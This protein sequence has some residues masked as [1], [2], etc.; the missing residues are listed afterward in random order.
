MG[1]HITIFLDINC[2]QYQNIIKTMQ[3]NIMD[4]EHPTQQPP[5]M[6]KPPFPLHT[7][8]NIYYKITMN[9]IIVIFH[10]KN[11][12]FIAKNTPKSFRY[13]TDTIPKEAHTQNDCQKSHY[14]TPFLYTKSQVF[15]KIEILIL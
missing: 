5:N 10:T 14:P 1:S 15:H 11:K 12:K 2:L 13:H 7:P 8:C 6:I 3:K 9:F 4:F